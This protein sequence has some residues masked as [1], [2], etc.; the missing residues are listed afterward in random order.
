MRDYLNGLI[1]GLLAI[2]VFLLTVG[3]ASAQPAFDDRLCAPLDEIALAVAQHSAEGKQASVE[4]DNG[5]LR[6]LIDNT[7][8][9]WA[10]HPS[11]APVWCMQ[12]HLGGQGA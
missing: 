12:E 1:L 5:N 3:A 4:N 6:V 7:L 9:V 11:G 10:P 2:T 8:T